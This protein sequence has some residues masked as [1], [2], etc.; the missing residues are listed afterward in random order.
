MFLQNSNERKVLSRSDW[1]DETIAG[2]KLNIEP[3]ATGLAKAMTSLVESQEIPEEALPMAHVASL[4]RSFIGTMIATQLGA[5]H[6]RTSKRASLEFMMLA[7]HSSALLV[8]HSS[9]KIL[10]NGAPTLE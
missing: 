1:V 10:L 3:L 8:H 5:M 2:W 7:C 4:L 6:R 9:L